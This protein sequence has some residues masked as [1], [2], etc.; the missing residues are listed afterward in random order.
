MKKTLL[1]TLGSL[2]ALL[3]GVSPAISNSNGAPA[4]RSGSPASSGTTC[5]VSGCHTGGPAASTQLISITSDIPA[6][7]FEP[8]TTYTFTVTADG[9]G[10]THT[11]LGFEASIED[12]GG[13]HQG[14]LTAGTGSKLVGASKYATHTTATGVVNNSK[15]WTFTW[16]SGSA[17]NNSTVYVAVNFANGNGSTSGDVILT[18]TEVL[19]KA[20]GIGLDE[21]VVAQVQ[22]A[23]NPAK[24]VA[25]LEIA[26]GNGKPEA[27]LYS[28]HGQWLGAGMEDGLGRLR[29]ELTDLPQGMYLV[30]WTKGK[31][32]GVERLLVQN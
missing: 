26:G 5:A 16:N 6:T 8:N 3:I 31:S 14:T 22:L 17:V 28:V 18:A 20:S 11:R 15:S 25:H 32:N 10:A 7:G 30:R 23:P 21:E 19:T 9:N 27:S 24:S 2:C 4:G 1:L 29:F 13:V 12:A